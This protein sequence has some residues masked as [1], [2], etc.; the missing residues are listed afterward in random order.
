[1]AKAV[2]RSQ[3]IEYYMHDGTKGSAEAIMR[4]LDETQ[5]GLETVN[6]LVDLFDGTWAIRSYWPNVDHWD[7]AT[8]TM[9]KQDLENMYVKPN[10]VVYIR[11]DVALTKSY[12]WFTNNYEDVGINQI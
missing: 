5:E 10:W 6:T 2:L 3:I 1:V 8:E 7:S 9:T 11:N 4:V 12:K